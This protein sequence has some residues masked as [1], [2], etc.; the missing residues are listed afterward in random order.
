MIKIYITK[1]IRPALRATI[2]SGSTRLK[3]GTATKMVLNMISTGAMALSGYVY[4]GLMVG[5]R[6]VNA[7]LWDR[8][9][10]IVSALTGKP[11]GASATLLREADG[12]IPVAILMA[13]FNAD[14]AFPDYAQGFIGAELKADHQHPAVGLFHQGKQAEIRIHPH[15]A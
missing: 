5:M 13:H 6:P 15:I 8:A 11:P 2:S 10:R 9:I 1:Y 14:A 4:K 3:A 7:K 12:R